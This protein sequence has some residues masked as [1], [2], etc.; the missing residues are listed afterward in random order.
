MWNIKI[1]PSGYKCCITTRG[2]VEQHLVR[3]CQEE[4]EKFWFLPKGYAGQKQNW[5]I[6]G[7]TGSPVYLKN[8]C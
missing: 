4:Y 5:K 3:W 1:M 6:M 2:K 8:G 7:A